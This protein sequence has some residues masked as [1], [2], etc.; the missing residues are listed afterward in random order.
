MPSFLGR[1]IYAGII[2]GNC[3]NTCTIDKKSS[4][5]FN[6]L[7]SKLLEMSQSIEK[8]IEEIKK[9]CNTPKQADGFLFASIETPEMTI[10][11]GEE[12]IIYM[13]RHGPPHHGKFDH[14]KLNHIRREYNITV[15]SI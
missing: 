8:R 10:C 14:H 11:I 4:I 12:Y 7:A 2:S 9:N 6:T 5:F 3:C 15:P 1:G 13:Q